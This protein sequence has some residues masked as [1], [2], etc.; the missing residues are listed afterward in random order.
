MAE[1]ALSFV[2]PR[3][4]G[5]LATSIDAYRCGPCDRLYPIIC[6]VPDFRLEPDPYIGL[7]E[8]RAKA[9]RLFEAGRTRSFEQLVRY[10]YS[11]TPDDPPDLAEQWTR[12]HLAEEAIADALLTAACL[13]DGGGRVVLDLGCSTGGLVVAASRRRWQ[14]TG[15]DVAL[16]WLVVGRKRLEEAGVTGVLVCANAQHLPLPAGCVDAVTANDLLEHSGNPAG[17]LTEA[18]RVSKAGATAVVTA[19]NR[20]A[21]LPEPQLK[22]WGVTQMPRRWQARFVASRRPDLHRYR[23]IVPSARELAR[24]LVDA[25][26][27]AVRVEPA[28]L[29]APHWQHGGLAR[30]LAFYNAARRLPVIRPLLLLAGPRLWG[31]AVR[32]ATPVR[33]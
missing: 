2:C 33:R 6:G 23:M 14:A 31:Q 1:S 5:P 8:D 12:H 16:R 29:V 30:A 20:Y 27:E 19:N 17:V 22:V 9:V 4:R 28:P 32:S 21:P 25:G 24:W 26:F 18:H 13:G 3:C 10:Y 15:V 11:I 7:A